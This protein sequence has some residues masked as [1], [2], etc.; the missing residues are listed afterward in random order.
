MNYRRSLFT[1]R[2][3]FRSVLAFLL[4]PLLFAFLATA[5]RAQ[6]PGDDI[7][8]VDASLVRLNVGVAD[9]RGRAITDLARPDFV[10]YE[11]GVKQ[12]ITNFEPTQTPFSLVLLLDMSGSTLRFRQTLVQAAIRF[13]DALAPADRV[14]IVSFSARKKGDKGQIR[15]IDQLDLLAGFSSDR[16]KLAFA[17]EGA[18]GSGETNLYKALDYSL[19][20]LAKEQTRRKAIVV[21]TDGIDTDQSKQDRLA[22]A[23][24]ETG[25]AALAAVKPEQNATLNAILNAADR[26]GVTVYPMALPSGDPARIPI[27]TPQQIAIYGAA[28]TRLQALANRTGGRLHAINR[29]E[30]MGRI[31]AEVAAEMRTLYSIVYQS[32]NAGTR[33]GK[34]RA[35]N[36]EVTRPQLIARTRPGYYAR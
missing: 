32:T 31:Y 3:H 5:A 11:D 25:E 2:E 35:I 12:T 14:A 4:L 34:W 28:R 29:L 36:I 20:L 19:G 1:P 10:V 26:Q 27:P 16:S 24:A 23:A 30:D 15:T 7:I 18:R 33:D 6:E 13:L 8:S 22:A 21:L 17:I 9:L